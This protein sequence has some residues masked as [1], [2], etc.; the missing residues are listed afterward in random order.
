MAHIKNAHAVAHGMVFVVDT[1]VGN[2]HVIP[3]KLR[4]FGAQLL[5]NVR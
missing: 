1:T 2:G 5:V 4:H 3:G